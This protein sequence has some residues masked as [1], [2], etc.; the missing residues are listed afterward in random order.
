MCLSPLCAV[1][2]RNTLRCKLS[3]IQGHI[4]SRVQDMMNSVSNS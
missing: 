1:T 2:M 3:A 4:M